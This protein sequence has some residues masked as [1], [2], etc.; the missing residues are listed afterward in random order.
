MEAVLQLEVGRRKRLLGEEKEDKF[1]RRID[2]EIGVIAAVSAVGPGVLPSNV[3]HSSVRWDDGD[4]RG[5]TL[6]LADLP[7]HK[8]L[9]RRVKR[10]ST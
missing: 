9:K 7:G 4:N 10:R 5:L 8:W 3:R 1:F 6:A 2:A